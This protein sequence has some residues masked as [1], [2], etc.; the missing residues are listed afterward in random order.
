MDLDISD[1]NQKF[2]KSDKKSNDLQESTTS[3]STGYGAWYLKPKS[4]NDFY[5]SCRKKRKNTES[6]KHKVKQQMKTTLNATAKAFDQFIKDN[7]TYT[8]TK[9]FIEILE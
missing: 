5:E 6:T 8:K 4:W 3:N 2:K 7:K 1:L 9:T